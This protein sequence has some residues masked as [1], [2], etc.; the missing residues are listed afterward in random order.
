[1]VD[2]L[3][4]ISKEIFGILEQK[5]DIHQKTKLRIS[6]VLHDVS[7]ILYD[8][9]QK[10]K[11]NEYPHGNCVVMERLSNDL[12]FHISEFVSSQDLDR[13]T[14]SLKKS[15]E[16]EKLFSIRE[17]PETI[18]TIEKAAGEFKSLSL[19]LRI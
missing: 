16:L 18:P 8:T 19:F 10:L 17:E 5:K 3:I 14:T 4:D 6:E 2:I 13:L 11:N 1:M 9:S 12:G 15:V 7:S